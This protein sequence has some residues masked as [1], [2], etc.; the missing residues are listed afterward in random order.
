MPITQ[1]VRIAPNLRDDLQQRDLAASGKIVRKVTPATVTT[2]PKI[3]GDKSW[4]RWVEI[5]YLD[6]LSSVGGKRH[7]W[8]QGTVNV[9]IAD[10]VTATA[11]VLSTSVSVV[12]GYARVKVYSTGGNS[13]QGG[14]DTLTVKQQSILG[15]TLST[16]TSVETFS[17]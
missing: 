6:A 8:Y 7:R 5:E 10:T 1:D 14:T 3:A 13:T 2:A 9:S 11:K 16:Q 12:D 17:T 4:E 15:V